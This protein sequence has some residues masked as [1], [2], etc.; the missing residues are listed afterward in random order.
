MGI[1]PDILQ[2]ADAEQLRRVDTQRI[3]VFCDALRLKELRHDLLK[4]NVRETLIALTGLGL[5]GPEGLGEGIVELGAGIVRTV[6]AKIGGG[7][8]P[9]QVAFLRVDVHQGSVQV[10]NQVGIL[11]GK[12]SFFFLS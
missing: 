10:K 5:P 3:R 12:T 2:G 1:E 9:H 4:G 11:H 6:K 7:L 8:F